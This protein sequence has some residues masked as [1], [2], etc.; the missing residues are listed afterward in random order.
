MDVLS[1]IGIALALS[2]DSFA[3]A[4]SCGLNCKPLKQNYKIFI[5]LSFSIFQSG[6]P[7]IGYFAGYKV[8]QFINSWD[9]WLAFGLLFLIGAHM[10]REGF[11]HHKS[12]KQFTVTVKMILT[13]SLATSIDALAT[14]FSFG[15]LQVD[16][17]LAVGIIFLVTFIASILGLKAGKTIRQPGMK[18][19]AVIIGGIILIAI[20]MKVLITHLLNH[21][22]LR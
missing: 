16:I 7:L 11:V 21:G 20:G 18:K 8:L 19:W 9:H 2:F 1:I 22:F 17:W 6:M 10:I 4:I 14:G 12:P 3:V 13:L 15:L 5:L